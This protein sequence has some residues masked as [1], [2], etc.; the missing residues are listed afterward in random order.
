[1]RPNDDG[2]YPLTEWGINTPFI[3]NCPNRISGGQ[4]S[5]DLI[6]LSDVLPSIADFAGAGLPAGVI[7]DGHSFAPQL[8]G[9]PLKSPW[10]QWCL[11]QYHQVRVIRDHRFK[12]LSSGP[13]FD[14]SEDPLEQHDL[15]NSNRLSESNPTRDAHDK[16]KKVLDGLPENAKLPWEFRSISARQLEAAKAKQ[17]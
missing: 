3:V 13:F 1:M 17:N 12:L 14:L 2:Y 4:V 10:R 16:L 15:Q 7:L 11:T 6:D 8:R 9:E 5:D